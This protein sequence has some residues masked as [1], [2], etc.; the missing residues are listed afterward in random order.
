VKIESVE[1]RTSSATL[2]GCPRAAVP[3]VAISG[4]SNV[5]KSSLLNLMLKR[6]GL[7][8]V[9]ATPGKTQLLNF[10]WVNEQFHLVDLPGYGYARVPGNVQRNWQKMMQSYLQNREPL[11]GVIQLIDS[12]HPPSAQD[13]QMVQ[14]LLEVD[15]PFCLVLTKM[16][17]LKQNE[18]ARA[19]PRML[20][21]LAETVEL[22]G[23]L[24][25]L[26]TSSKSGEGQR[27]LLDWIE[28]VLQT[29]REV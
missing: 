23:E 17:K 12:R 19:V 2:E 16:D 7:A 5:G 25:I 28:W 18:R 9:S 11:T 15:I 21:S 29:V 10:F 27:Q 26:Q 6:K 3:E 22:P 13:V 1:F 8:R 4:R 24:P 14:W 20:K